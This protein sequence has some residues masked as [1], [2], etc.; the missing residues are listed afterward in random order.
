MTWYGRN[1]SSNNGSTVELEEESELERE[2]RTR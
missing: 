1:Y 2:R